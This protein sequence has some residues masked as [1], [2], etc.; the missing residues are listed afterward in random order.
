M[1]C[2]RYLLPFLAIL[3]EYLSIEIFGNDLILSGSLND[4]TYQARDVV[5]LFMVAGGVLLEAC[6][7]KLF[8]IFLLGAW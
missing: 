7:E 4:T 6:L 3:Y 8:V 5:E 1:I 2:V